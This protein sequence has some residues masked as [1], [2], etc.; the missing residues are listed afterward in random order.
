MSASTT[1]GGRYPSLLNYWRFG[2]SR[3]GVIIQLCTH[4][5]AHQAPG[6]CHTTVTQSPLIKLCWVTKQN[7]VWGCERGYTEERV[8]RGGGR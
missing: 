8:T 6:Q 1:D 2:E 7:K 5:L 3:R 4:W